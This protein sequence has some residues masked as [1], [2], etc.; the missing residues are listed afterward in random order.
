MKSFDNSELFQLPLFAKVHWWYRSTRM[1]LQFTIACYLCYWCARLYEEDMCYLSNGSA[2][3]YAYQM[4]VSRSIAPN[5]H[6]LKHTY[7]DS[8]S[9]TMNLPFRWWQ[10]PNE[11]LHLTKQLTSQHIT[12]AHNLHKLFL[13][14]VEFS[15]VFSHSN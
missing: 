1:K 7:N 15:N 9:I 11:A 8:M 10:I 14:G 4:H 12:R 5:S 3:Q 2:V 13:A 6:L